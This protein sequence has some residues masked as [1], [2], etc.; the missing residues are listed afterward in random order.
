MDVEYHYRPPS[1]W[2]IQL[3]DMELSIE[4]QCIECWVSSNSTINMHADCRICKK[5][6]GL[7][8]WCTREGCICI[9]GILK[10]NMFA[11]LHFMYR[12]NGWTA[13]RAYA[14]GGRM[15]ACSTA[16]AAARKTMQSLCVFSYYIFYLKDLIATPISY[17]CFSYYCE[18]N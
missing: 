9:C 13:T 2:D 14:A 18:Q 12:L 5:K 11:W 17:S 10:Q 3:Q 6:H 4:I 8:G 1:R 7:F 15:P 16:D